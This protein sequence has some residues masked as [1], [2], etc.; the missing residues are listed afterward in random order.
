MKQ[1]LLRACLVNIDDN[2]E[3]RVEC[4]ASEIE[5]AASLS[6]IRWPVAFMSRTLS[7]TEKKYP[8]AAREASAIIIETVRKLV[9][10]LHAGRFAL[11]RTNVP[12]PSC[13]IR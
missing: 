6:Q 8:T 1:G 7:P 2:Q 12:L 5:I 3:L 10:F 4:D 13:Y 9:H 11:S